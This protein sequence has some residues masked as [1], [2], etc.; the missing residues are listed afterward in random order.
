MVW[1][2]EKLEYSRFN[3]NINKEW[4]H[5]NTLSG[6]LFSYTNEAY[7]I[8]CWALC[9]EVFKILGKDLMD[10]GTRSGKILRLGIP[11]APQGKIKGKPKA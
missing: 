3:T 4:V 2:I 5:Y 7:E 9:F 8:F 6:G 1:T 10:F 11:N